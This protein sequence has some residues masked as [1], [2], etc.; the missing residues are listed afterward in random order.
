MKKFFS[1][2]CAMLISCLCF[3][4][5]TPTNNNDYETTDMPDVCSISYIAVIDGEE[6]SIP[7]AM[8]KDD[9]E[10]PARYLETQGAKVDDLQELIVG[11]T[12]YTF[13]GWYL[14]KSVKRK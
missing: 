9:G 14:E 8:Y 1:L 4:G 6:A 10:Y 7:V 2:L 13:I 5:C 12:T 3:I 11:R